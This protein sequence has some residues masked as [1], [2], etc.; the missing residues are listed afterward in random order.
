MLIRA[1]TWTC[2]VWFFDPFLPSKTTIKT[3]VFLWRVIGAWTWNII[4]DWRWLGA[5]SYFCTLRPSLYL[6]FIRIIVSRS[7]SDETFFN[8][9]AAAQRIK[10]CR[11]STFY[12]IGSWTWTNL[13]I[14]FV[15]FLFPYRIAWLCIEDRSRFILHILLPTSPGPGISLR[16]YS[17]NLELYPNFPSILLF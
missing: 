8:Y 13:I 1:R 12:F 14:I 16:F 15:S 2:I 11:F 5:S 3:F 4:L 10:R 9:S 17:F 6:A 7:R